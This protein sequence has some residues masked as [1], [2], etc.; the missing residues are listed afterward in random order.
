MLIETSE[1]ANDYFKQKIM[2]GLI[3]YD[4]KHK[5]I[6]ILT[7]YFVPHETMRC[8]C[9][10]GKSKAKMCPYLYRRGQVSGQASFT[11]S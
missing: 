11:G 7:T 10:F 6:T 2:F 4:N 8:M 9:V 1:I 5:K 3:L